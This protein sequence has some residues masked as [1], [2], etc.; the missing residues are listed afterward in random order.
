MLRTSQKGLDKRGH[1]VLVIKFMVHVNRSELKT[2]SVFD[3]HEMPL[4]SFARCGVH[5]PSLLK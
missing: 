4:L 2:F 1:N 5:D 3:G